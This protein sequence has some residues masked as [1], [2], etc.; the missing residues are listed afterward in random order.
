LL[1]VCYLK[2][3]VLLYCIFS[4]I[5]VLTIDGRVLMPETYIGNVKFE[6]IEII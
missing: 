1:H 2:F 5:T 4:D 3:L 6:G